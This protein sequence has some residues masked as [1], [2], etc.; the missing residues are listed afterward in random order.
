MSEGGDWDMSWDAAARSLANYFSNPFWSDPMNPADDPAIAAALH[1][2]MEVD[3]A[4]AEIRAKFVK[5]DMSD[6][7]A[8][9]MYSGIALGACFVAFMI[10]NAVAPDS[11]VT[12]V[13]RY[14]ASFS[15]LLVFLIGFLALVIKAGDRP[16]LRKYNA[17]LRSHIYAASCHRY[18]MWLNE[19]RIS[20]PQFYGQIVL[21]EQQQTVIK[22]Q[23]IAI[24]QQNAIIKNQQAAIKTQAETNAILNAQ[25]REAQDR[26]AAYQQNRR[27]GYI[28]LDGRF[29][30]Y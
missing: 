29:H 7:K 16:K 5:R 20:D 22:N 15:C 30:P 28:G 23:E 10:S 19:V 24:Q 6:L 11:T 3:S 8:A 14:P 1:D 17:A 21:W 18:Q 27:S 2:I 26:W 25:R 4:N 13:I 12:K 9:L